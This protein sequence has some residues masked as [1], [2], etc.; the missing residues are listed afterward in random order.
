[1]YSI[2]IYRVAG[3]FQLG[4]LKYAFSVFL[5]TPTLYPRKDG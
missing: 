2:Y 1:M 5:Y 3:T 4:G